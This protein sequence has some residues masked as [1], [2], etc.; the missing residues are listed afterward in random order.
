M[1]TRIYLAGGQIDLLCISELQFIFIY[2]ALEKFPDIF[3]VQIVP[4]ASPINSG[5]ELSTIK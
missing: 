3:Y 1:I 5:T 4:N 2:F